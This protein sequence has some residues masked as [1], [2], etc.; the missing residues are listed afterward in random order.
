MKCIDPETST[1]R[2]GFKPDRIT[3]GLVAKYCQNCNFG[4]NGARTECPLYSLYERQQEIKP[5]TANKEKAFQYLLSIAPR[6]QNLLPYPITNER[7]WTVRKGSPFPSRALLRGHYPF[8]CMPDGEFRFTEYPSSGI[9]IFKIIPS[10]SRSEIANDPSLA[11][12]PKS[13]RSNMHHPEIANGREVIAPGMFR[14]NGNEIDYVSN[15]SGH[16][17]PD[18]DCISF[19][20]Q[21][22]N[23]WEIPFSPNL[24]TKSWYS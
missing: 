5:Q 20:I 10:P 16:Y 13:N 3:D 18:P 22:G 21:I 19:A 12:K 15:E 1:F 6:Y 17:M 4:P 23:Y 24:K 9:D 7:I 8:V 11:P 2:G 14:W